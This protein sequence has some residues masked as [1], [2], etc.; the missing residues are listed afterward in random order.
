MAKGDRTKWRILDRNRIVVTIFYKALKETHKYEN[1]N[2][3]KPDIFMT[4]LAE[5]Y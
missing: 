5:A 2:L 3:H 1:K 4:V